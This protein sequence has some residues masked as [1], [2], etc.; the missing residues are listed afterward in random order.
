MLAV[1]VR[2]R[3][4][5]C[6]RFVCWVSEVVHR[7]NVENEPFLL[8][9][10]ICWGFAKKRDSARNG[11]ESANEALSDILICVHLDQAQG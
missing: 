9:K 4:F 1:L 2:F 11:A 10:S 3:R 5:W 7:E 6:E 8:M